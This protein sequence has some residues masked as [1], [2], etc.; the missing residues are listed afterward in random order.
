MLVPMAGRRTVFMLGLGALAPGVAHAVPG[1]DSVAVVANGNDLESVALARLYLEARQIPERQLCLLDLPSEHTID[2]ATYEARFE[3]PLFACLDAAG[4]SDRIEAVVLARGVPLRV[5]VPTATG[6]QRASLAAT[7]GV[8]RSVTATAA[9]HRLVGRPPGAR[10]SCGGS[11]CLGA[12]W[13][14]PYTAGPFSAE[15]SA[16]VQGILHRP[17]LVTML[18]GRSYLDAAQLVASATTADALGGAAGQFLFMNGADA[19]RGV[20]DLY[21]DQIVA[22]LV[23]RGFTDAERVPFQRDLTGRSLAA[24]FVGTAGLGDTIEGNAFLPGA[25]VDNLT[26]FG[27][28]P[29]N[30]EPSGESQVSIARWVS[31]GVAGVH[32]TTDE[33]LNNCFPN[34]RLILAYVDGYTLAE[35]YFRYMPFVY[36]RNLVLGDPITAPYARRPQVDL[37]GLEAGQV[38]GSTEVTVRASSEGQVA[39]IDLFV[40][41]VR[42]ASGPGPELQACLPVPEGEAIQVLAVA[43]RADDGSPGSAPTPKGWRAVTV[44]GLPGP[45]DCPPPEVDA[46]TSDAGD[47]AGASPPDAGAPTPDAGTSAPDAGTPDTGAP[48][49]E[50]GGCRATSGPDAAALGLFLAGLALLGR[51]RRM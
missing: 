50:E 46:G 6:D 7:L 45:P 17:L 51:R 29:V 26:S 47:D 38:A 15:W 44:R 24:F 28:V 21:F 12:T 8:A 48:A 11:T 43:Q 13:R 33:P 2:L 40:D 23:D 25:L 9:E 27:A 3:A 49:L 14:N 22:G 32:G 36:W 18:H 31:K 35:S 20:L 16:E 4:V 1:P 39:R 34:R 37:Q 41:G 19:A 10:I 42:V 30:F 5:T